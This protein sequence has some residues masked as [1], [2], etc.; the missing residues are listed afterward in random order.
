MG[1]RYVSCFRL[2]KSGR[3]AG[4]SRPAIGT[5]SSRFLR[6]PIQPQPNL[7]FGGEALALAALALAA[8]ALAA[9]PLPG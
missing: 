1:A 5:V 8:L 3:S 7:V 9:P 2:V 6:T 4:V